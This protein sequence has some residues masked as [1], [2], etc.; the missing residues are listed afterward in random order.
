MR[1]QTWNGH[2][3]GDFL[4]QNY[5]PY[6]HGLDLL[7]SSPEHKV[8]FKQN[9]DVFCTK[10]YRTNSCLVWTFVFQVEQ[11]LN[12]PEPVLRGLLDKFSKVED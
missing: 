11:L 9:F 10:Y 1:H 7:L 4:K 5:L 6:F 3:V 12:I 2:H 8:K